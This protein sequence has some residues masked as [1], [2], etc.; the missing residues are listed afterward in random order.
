MSITTSSGS[1]TYTVVQIDKHWYPV[2]VT[3]LYSAQQQDGYVYLYDLKQEDG[4]DVAYPR[5][6]DAL[7]YCRREVQ[8]QDGYEQRKWE[9]LIDRL[10]AQPE[11]NA[12]YEQIIE[13]ITGLPPVIEEHFVSVWVTALP[14]HCLRCG[15]VHG[16]RF[17]IG[18]SRQEALSRVAERVYQVYSRCMGRPVR[19]PVT[20]GEMCVSA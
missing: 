4:T 8:Q 20:D 15:E 12:H 14:Y 5:R 16:E 13:E 7:E 9:Q 18:L 10:D 2:Q 6:S 1:E 11:R 17:A 3:R 19:Q